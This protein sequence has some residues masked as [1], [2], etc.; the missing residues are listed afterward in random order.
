MVS[1]AP[2]VQAHWAPHLLSPT[3]RRVGPWRLGLVAAV[4]LVSA[5]CST[6]AD[7]A[8]PLPLTSGSGNDTEAV[9]S[10]DGG[11][12]VFQSD[13][14]GTLDLYQLDLA[15]K[16][17]T[18]LVT[19]PGHA[20][21]PAFSPDGKWIVYSYA[22]FTTTAFEGIEHGYNLYVVPAEG[23]QARR[24][25]SGRHR[26]YCPRFTP[27][28]RAIWFASDRASRGTR[29]TNTVN[30]FSVPLNGGEPQPVTRHTTGGAATV[31]LSFSPDGRHLV[32]SLVVGFRGNWVIRLAKT[33]QL[34]SAYPLTDP[35]TSFYAPQ[36][37]P[38]A[39]WIAATGFVVG[40]P[41]WGIYLIDAK[42][43][44]RM[45]LATGPGN[46]RTPAFAPDGKSLVYENNHT[47]CYKLYRIDVPS[48]ETAALPVEAGPTSSGAPL[49]TTSPD[50]VLH[51]PLDKKPEAAVVDDGSPAGNDGTIHGTVEFDGGAARFVKPGTY[52]TIPEARGFDFGAGPFSVRATVTVSEGDELAFIAMGEYPGNRLGWQLYLS[53]DRRAQF[54]SRD[55]DLKYCG[56]ASDA[57][58]PLERP[59]T[60]V[61]VRDESGTVRL[62]VDG[63]L[64]QRCCPGATWQ[65]GVPVQVRI[66]SQY[67]GSR[68]L[69][70]RLHEVTVW[71]RALSPDEIRGDSLQRFWAE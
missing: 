54:N 41:G 64:Q 59:V 25:T 63:A 21:F 67:D 56:A 8:G 68:R 34:A 24:L 69:T 1:N 33:D 55:S 2:S 23:G 11:R 70:G 45:R 27:D 42:T 51:Y 17:V 57:P 6:P 71:R 49:S 35:M 48:L 13:R 65:Y 20:C 7:G 46:A 66:G 50:V 28:G 36:F 16:E 29:Q 52:V 5:L 14:S 60:L 26:D 12:V 10:P 32:Y 22:H 39:D 9:V 19:G 40:D 31:G 30:L 38:A 18:S 43:G 47:G 62:F 58:L 4:L 37:S 3:P 15:T 53:A 44:R 61:G